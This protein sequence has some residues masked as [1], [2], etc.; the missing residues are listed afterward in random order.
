MNKF[1]QNSPSTN[2]FFPSIL[3]NIAEGI[4]VISLDKKLIFLG[5]SLF[6]RQRKMVQAWDFLSHME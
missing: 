1:E 4:V 5:F 6:T 3:E 2:I